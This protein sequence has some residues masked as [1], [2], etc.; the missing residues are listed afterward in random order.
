MFAMQRL[1]PAGIHFFLKIGKFASMGS[2]IST[3]LQQ[4]FTILCND[5]VAPENIHTPHGRFFGFEPPAT[6]TPQPGNSSLA[7]YFPLK[8]IAFEIPSPLEFPMTF[9]GGGWIFSG[10][11]MTI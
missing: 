9:L 7:S 1:P 8:K 2:Y 6:P 11:T 4:I 5:C 10:T 3:G